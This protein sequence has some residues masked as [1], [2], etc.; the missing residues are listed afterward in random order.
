MGKVIGV[1]LLGCAARF[2]YHYRGKVETTGPVV[3]TAQP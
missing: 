2:V 3:S 1:L